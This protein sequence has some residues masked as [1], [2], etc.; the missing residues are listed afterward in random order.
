[1]TKNG[2]ILIVDDEKNLRNTLSKVLQKEN[3]SVTGASNAQEALQYLQAGSFDITFLDLMLP[4][5]D[6]LTLLAKI[7][8]MYPEMP[9]LI[10][11]ANASLESAIE[12]VRKGARD[13]LLKPVDP[14]R[15][16][17]RI[18]DI[19]KEQLQPKRQREIVGQIQTLVGELQHLR[20]D[21]H[22]SAELLTTLPPTDPARFLKRGSFTLD[23]HARHVT[24]DGKLIPLSP[25]NFDYLTTLIRHCPDPVSYVELVKESQGYELTRIEA[26][27]MTRWRIH[28]LRKAIEPEPKKPQNIITVRGQGYR[29]VV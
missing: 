14:P 7:R 28:E 5:M 17:A 15:I 4:G 16:I 23:L 24:L 18:N 22:L 3:F 10:L 8:E 9:V 12:A 13:Y 25:T 1:M 27:E 20:G 2:T 6:G 21:V 11:T 29:I 26:Q 19:L